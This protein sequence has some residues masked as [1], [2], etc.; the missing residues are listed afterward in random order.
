MN[1]DELRR[2]GGLYVLELEANEDKFDDTVLTEG[3]AAYGLKS[4]GKSN[5]AALLAEQ[6]GHNHVPL[7]VFDLE[8]VCQS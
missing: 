6:V 5:G 4:A 8:N 7:V 3:L 1:E 2:R